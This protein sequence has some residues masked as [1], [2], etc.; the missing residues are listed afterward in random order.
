MP[1]GA[2]YVTS[3]DGTRIWA[4][5]AGDPT[6]PAVV[7]IH[8]MAST[9]FA[10][11]AQFVDPA[12]LKS[13][14]MVRYEMRGFGRS[15]MPEALEAYASIHQADDFRAVCEGFNLKRPVPVF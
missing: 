10:F 13:L 2:K 6:K 7:F 4:E 8:G 12:M 9:A 11:N 1:E 3:A 15:G 14:H 5:S